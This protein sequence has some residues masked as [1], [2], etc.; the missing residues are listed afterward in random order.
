MAQVST[1]I[2]DYELTPL[3][4]VYEEVCR[5]AKVRQLDRQMHSRE[6]QSVRLTPVILII[7][8][9]EICKN[10]HVL[11]FMLAVKKGCS[12]FLFDYS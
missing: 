7:L 11:L 4:V 3:H 12:I 6:G 8:S 9:G 10:Y 5:G 1:N 2:L